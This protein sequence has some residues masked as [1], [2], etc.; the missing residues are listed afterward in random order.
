MENFP[1]WTE[2]SPQLRSGQALCL[3]LQGLP[4]LWD[5]VVFSGAQQLPLKALRY[6]ELQNRLDTGESKPTHA[7]SSSTQHPAQGALTRPHPGSSRSGAWQIPGALQREEVKVRAGDRART[8]PHEPRPA[9]T[10]TSQR[11]EQCLA[12]PG[13]LSSPRPP[14]SPPRTLNELAQLKLRSF[15]PSVPLAPSRRAPGMGQTPQ[16]LS[17]QLAGTALP[18]PL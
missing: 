6:P 9:A 17:S 4:W 16:L 2:H 18:S 1:G 15:P 10:P 5:A 7:G 11:A 12:H 14:R 3:P 13:G 8:A